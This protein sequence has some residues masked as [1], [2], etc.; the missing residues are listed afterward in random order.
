MKVEF[1]Y[2]SKRK[3]V[4]IVSDFFSNIKEHF[5]V[6]NKAAHF[7][8]FGR[9]MPQRIYAITPAGYC[10][11]GLVPEIIKYL[12]TL[13]IPF[14]IEFNTELTTLFSRLHICTPG[15]NIKKLDC[16][17][18]LRDYQI[19]AI[20]RAMDRGYGI[21]EVATGGGK[22]FIISNLVY[23]ALQHIEYTEKVLIVVPDIGLVEQTYKDFTSYNFP[24]KLVTKWTG[25]NE[26]DPNCRVIIANMGILQSE[27]SDL[28]WFAEVGLLIVDECHKLRRG[29]KICKLL[30]K[31]PTLR[32]IGFTGTLPEDDIDKWNIFNFIG[33]VIFKK[34]TTELREIAGDRYIANAQALSVF[35]QYDRVP[36]YT[37]VAAMQKYRLELNF[38]H[39]NNYRNK[40]IKS[41]VEKLNNNCLILIDHI[42]HGQALYNILAPID[43]K[44]VY[45][46]QGS[47]EVEDRIKIQQIMEAHN[48]VVCVAISKIFSTGISIKNIHYIMFAAGGKSKIKTLQSIGR[49]LRTHENKSVLTLIDIVDDL[50]Y[51]KA[52]YTKRKEFYALEKI[53][54][55]EKTVTESSTA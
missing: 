37:S 48:N 33:P 5:S 23:G 50:V 39:S 10:G 8:K 47:V 25:N 19:E 53:K 14:Q 12:K 26:L 31:V 34:T 2:D 38:I 15:S 13:D 27:K 6:R 28:S 35:L 1:N 40:I 55:T 29:N 24:M 52:H 9:F 46:I 32:R 20:G 4:K 21:I 51:G 7:N 42:D 36:D 16:S 22:T 17:F 43:N 44:Q 30:D 18:D 41:I 11:V 54:I 45:F 49:G 3:E